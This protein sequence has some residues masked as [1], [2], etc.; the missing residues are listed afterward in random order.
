M[1]RPPTADTPLAA[2]PLGGDPPAS[3]CPP[4]AAAPLGAPASPPASVRPAQRAPR[5][6]PVPPT[7]QSIRPSV[8]RSRPPPRAPST[9]AQPSPLGEALSAPGGR[10]SNGA[11]VAPRSS[12]ALARCH[13]TRHV[14]LHA[15]Q[16][17]DRWMV[18]RLGQGGAHHRPP[19]PREQQASAT[20]AR[21][22]QHPALCAHR[23]DTAASSS[24]R[25]R[26]DARNSRGAA[27]TSW[28]ASAP[29]LP[30]E[31]PCQ[32]L[33]SLSSSRSL[34]ARRTAR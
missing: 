4:E 30:L 24:L 20:S 29:G 12:P 9:L 14:G 3:G 27:N 34:C 7:G 26:L 17:T 10:P 15:C 22:T 21:L 11:A 23:A 1:P 18:I 25:R 16:R 33:V 6:P 2:T 28:R 13:A 5:R 31:V 8:A 32:P 19:H